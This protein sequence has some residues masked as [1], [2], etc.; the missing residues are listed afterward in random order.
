MPGPEPEIHLDDQL[1]LA[2][3]VALWWADEAPE[4]PAEEPNEDLERFLDRKQASLRM[5]RRNR[6][7]FPEPTGSSGRTRLYRVGDLVSW[8]SGEV[9][10]KEIAS[11]ELRVR[12]AR[13]SPLWHLR[14]A[15]DV[16]RS[17]LD[18]DA[19][20]RLAVAVALALD[21]LGA[22]AGLGQTPRAMALLTAAGR[23]TIRQMRL[24]GPSLEE[25]PPELGG[26][27]ESL[28]AGIPTRVAGAGRLVR[29]F[30]RYRQR[31][32]RSPPRRLD[33]GAPLPIPRQGEHTDGEWTRP[34]DGGC[35]RPPAGR[36]GHRPRGR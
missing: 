22:R 32:S 4:H 2:E 33:S 7:G 25:T 29:D 24:V 12:A 16:C 20:R 17:D 11:E 27:F 14:R 3:F 23:D 35:R 26:V 8:I 34:V 28:L 21:C 1:S 15:V 36:A 30:R 13:V 19:T 10:E 31:H 18:D 9:T 6:P 5:L